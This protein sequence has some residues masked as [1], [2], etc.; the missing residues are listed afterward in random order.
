MSTRIFATV[1]SAAYCF[2]IQDN[3]SGHSQIWLGRGCVGGPTSVDC[4]PMDFWGSES[5]ELKGL[6]S[7]RYRHRHPTSI[8]RRDGSFGI[9]R[10][11]CRTRSARSYFWAICFGFSNL[12]I[13]IGIWYLL[14]VFLRRKPASD[15]VDGWQRQFTISQLLGITFLLGALFGVGRLV[16]EFPQQSRAMVLLLLG[17]VSMTTLAGLIV[18]VLIMDSDP[19]DRRMR[20]KKITLPLNAKRPPEREEAEEER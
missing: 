8:D 15:A 10:A 7:D 20:S 6:P 11:T 12:G 2:Y 4:T 3:A 1:V 16:Y 14:L 13:A 18:N 19:P 17:L 5:T 9:H